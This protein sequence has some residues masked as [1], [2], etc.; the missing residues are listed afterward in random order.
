MEVLKWQL[1]ARKPDDQSDTVRGHLGNVQYTAQFR[2]DRTTQA[3][4]V[5][6]D[7]PI[8]A[9]AFRLPVNRCALR[10]SAHAQ[11]TM[12]LGADFFES[13]RWERVA[14]VV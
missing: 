11:V 3:A 6:N 4:D 13:E 9:S 12:F 14:C 10:L 7:F 5:G 2:I 1:T 8:P